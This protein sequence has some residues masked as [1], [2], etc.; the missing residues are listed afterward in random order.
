LRI[1]M[2]LPYPNPKTRQDLDPPSTL[3]SPNPR[4][5]N[6]T[7]SK[8]AQG[9]GVDFEKLNKNLNHIRKKAL[10]ARWCQEIH[11]QKVTSRTPGQ[12]Q[13]PA[14]PPPWCSV[15]LVDPWGWYQTLC[16]SAKK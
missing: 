5:M 13:D 2:S 16:P 3:Q 14:P 7:T 11:M 8:K 12:F 1:H 4:S 10:S 15:I 6:A 9:I